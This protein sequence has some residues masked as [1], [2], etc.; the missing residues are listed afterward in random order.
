MKCKIYDKECPGSY[1]CSYKRRCVEIVEYSK[2]LVASQVEKKLITMNY[3]E[4]KHI[5]KGMSDEEICH[6]MF[7]PHL[8][9]TDEESTD[10]DRF[11]KNNS[12]SIY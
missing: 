5:Y 3:K 7:W 9:Q 12:R 6:L 2:L 4:N 8:P 10:Q 11:R 1:H